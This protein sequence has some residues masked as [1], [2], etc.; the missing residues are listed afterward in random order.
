[1]TLRHNRLTGPRTL[2][3]TA[4]LLAPLTLL[5]GCNR[6]AS[7]STSPGGPGRSAVVTRPAAGSGA[8]RSSVDAPP[9]PAGTRSGVDV[10]DASPAADAGR[11]TYVQMDIGQ[12][13]SE[14]V[15]SPDGHA[16]LVDA[17]LPGNEGKILGVL[18]AHGVERLD[19]ALESHPHADHIGSMR[20]VIE[21]G[22]PVG[23]F[24][25]SGYRHTSQMQ[26]AL[27]QTL[28]S[29]GVKGRYVRA[30]DSFPLGDAVTVEIL[31]PTTLLHNTDS[32]PNN[33]SVVARVGYGAVHLLLAGDMEEDERRALL[34]GRAD[35]QSDAL[36]VAH[37]GSHNGTDADFLARVQPKVALISCA[38]G[39]DYGHPHDVALKMLTQ[40][41][42]PFY[43]TDLQ[44][45]IT[46]HSDGRALTVATEKQAI[47]P[48]TL[49]GNETA[50]RFGASSSVARSDSGDM[51]SPRLSER[52]IRRASSNAAPTTSNGS[53][54]R[55]S[56]AHSEGATGDADRK[57][58][59]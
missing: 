13:D 59:V 38:V 7:I 48:L 15:I 9:G 30:G 35:L 39:N 45:D 18:R 24:L 2:A 11:L 8:G 28:K 41:R 43:R 1:M 33:N 14:L 46:L 19:Y 22:P 44:G 37:H 26:T 31:A 56:A 29:K 55:G 12:G 52:G 3:W 10:G 32:D 25:A 34:A 51:T 21:Q 49:T 20:A 57:S 53:G 27:L 17:G 5:V 47:L 54:G 16:M 40:D 58:V 23:L 4:I 50:A 36:K 6:P 42:I